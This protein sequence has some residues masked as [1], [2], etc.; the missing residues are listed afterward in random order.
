MYIETEYKVDEEKRVI[1]CII[2]TMN[3]VQDRLEK[4]ELSDDKYD[5]DFDDIRIYKGIARCAPED[6]WD[7]AY[8]KRLAEYRASR[9][10][11]VDVNNELRKYMKGIMRCVDNLYDYGFLKDP[12]FPMH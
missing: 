2:T 4:Y 6:E 9:K 5:I 11:Q 3:D 12:H 1:V 10:R 8:G 7:E